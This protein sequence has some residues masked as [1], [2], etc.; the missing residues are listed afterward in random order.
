MLT[1]E[2][3]GPVK[4]G[5]LLDIRTIQY[6]LDILLGYNPAPWDFSYPERLEMIITIADGINTEDF[7]QRG[8]SW[9]NSII[10]IP[11]WTALLLWRW[12]KSRAS[13]EATVLST[14]IACCNVVSK[15]V[16][17]TLQYCLH[18][19]SF[20][21]NI[22]HQPYIQVLINSMKRNYLFM[23]IHTYLYTYTGWSINK[24]N[25]FKYQ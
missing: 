14:S 2:Q 5:K 4:I 21:H 13:T 7:K 15:S 25:I 16:R 8:Y 1:Q 6:Q 23:F 22:H 17:R 3:T 24:C 20:Y 19:P 18:S 12:E 11:A 9:Q 10:A